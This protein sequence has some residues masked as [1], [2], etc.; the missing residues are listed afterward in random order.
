MTTVANDL[1]SA[2]PPPLAKVQQPKA[3]VDNVRRHYQPT[4]E[5]NASKVGRS[6]KEGSVAYVE[7]Y[8]G[9]SR[10]ILSWRQPNTLRTG[11]ADLRF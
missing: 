6:R 3:L 7:G 9:K 1:L 10:S 2:L 4:C 5:E 11:D 8:L